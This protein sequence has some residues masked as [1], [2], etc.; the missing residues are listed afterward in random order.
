M[1]RP[2][3]SHV[4]RPLRWASVVLVLAILLLAPAAAAQATRPWEGRL[5]LSFDPV[6]G[7]DAI[8][9]ALALQPDGNILIGGAFEH[10]H[11]IARRGIARVTPTGAL[12]GAF[13]PGEGLG[14]GEWIYAIALQEDGKILIG[15]TFSTYD[16]VARN[17]IARL[18][19]DGTLDTTFD[20][21][22]GTD[23]EVYAIALQPDGKVLI[24]GAFT[25]CGGEPCAY[26]ARLNADGSLDA[27]FNPGVGPNDR[28]ESLAYLPEGGKVLIGGYFTEVG[29]QVRWHLARLNV[30]GTHDT[31]FTPVTLASEF[32]TVSA[33]VP[34]G[35]GRVLVGGSL[36]VSQGTDEF[37][38]IAR[39]TANG[40]LDATFA[41][42]TGTNDAVHALLAD[43]RG[44]PILGGA[45]GS[46]NGEA[47]AHLARLGGDGALDA[48]FD[49]GAG[50]DSLIYALALQPDGKIL[51][52]GDFTSYDGVARTR[53]A[54]VNAYGY[55]L[56]VPLAS[57]E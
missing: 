55:D 20:P 29:A 21:G 47:R 51:I 31:A 5:D 10:Y 56:F 24:G 27:T 11:A 36:T 32:A 1:H 2:T 52:A 41:P 53:L 7:A 45:F 19:A 37:L 28:V 15:G 6:A 22:A 40:A 35:D 34:L 4:T 54:R 38:G 42:G 12:D 3:Q 25:M 30:N 44:R 26:V 43:R 46:V 39:L 48:S 23:S 16:G 13:D 17:H 49:P 33:I 9:Y 14:L 8:I 50:A 57:R 18:N